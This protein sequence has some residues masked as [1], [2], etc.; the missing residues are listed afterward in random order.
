MVVNVDVQPKLN[1][2]I[3]M[4]LYLSSSIWNSA[5]KKELNRKYIQMNNE[6]DPASLEKG[7]W[8]ND[9]RLGGW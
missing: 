6:T 9:T 4:C 2:S 5:E 7:Q 1:I 3:K 8:P